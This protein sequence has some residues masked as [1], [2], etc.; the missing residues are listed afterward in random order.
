[1]CGLFGYL[2][3]SPC[4]PIILDGLSRLEY[5]G[6]DSAG[7]ATLRKDQI[8][9]TKSKGKVSKLRSLLKEELNSDY[10]G[11]GHTRWATHGKVCDINAHPHKAQDFAIVHNGIIENHAILKAKLVLEHNVEFISET[12][13]RAIFTLL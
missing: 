7:I 8:C 9:V 3:K 6:Y 10:I 5:R 1:M 11:I 2:G 13:S 12:D 4:M